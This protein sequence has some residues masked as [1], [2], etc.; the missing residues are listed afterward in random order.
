MTKIKIIL[1][2]LYLYPLYLTIFTG[3]VV[4]SAAIALLIS[5]C[6]WLIRF[7]SVGRHID[8]NDSFLDAV[9]KRLGVEH[10]IVKLNMKK[11]K[12]GAAGFAIPILPFYVNISNNDEIDTREIIIHELVHVHMAI[13]GFQVSAFYCFMIFM[14][15]AVFFNSI[16]YGVAAFVLV[17]FYMI[18][19]E[20]MAF[21][22]TRKIAREFGF[23]SR[24]FSKNIFIKYFVIY[25]LWMA[26]ALT[27]PY[28]VSS[29][30]SSQSV[31]FAVGIAIII[32]GL[33]L[34][35]KF[36]YYFSKWFNR[37]FK[38]SKNDN[39]YKSYKLNRL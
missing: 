3:A 16:A 8:D 21:N 35:N 24:Y 30:F 17:L 1:G 31:Q 19:Q 29:F 38:D 12:G 25:F 32:L 10:T 39:I 37:V 18:S 27:V 2:L 4:R 20:I 34:M 28:Y 5:I 13:Y 33:I 7:R 11:N 14:M 22:L 9:K 36:L 15:A 6:F 26:F 23:E